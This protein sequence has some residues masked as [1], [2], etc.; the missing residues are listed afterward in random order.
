MMVARSYIYG[1]V[2]NCEE[3]IDEIRE[4]NIIESDI[5]W[6]LY[7]KN[8]AFLKKTISWY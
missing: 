8:F 3:G 7:Q 2:R 4:T 1:R 5:M 6:R